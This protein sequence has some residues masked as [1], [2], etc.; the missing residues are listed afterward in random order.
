MDQQNLST[1]SSSGVDTCSKSEIQIKIKNPINQEPSN[2]K[3]VK[4]QKELIKLNEN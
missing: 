1:V 2:K 3:T 4:M